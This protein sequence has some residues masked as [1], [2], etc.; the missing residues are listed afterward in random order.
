MSEEAEDRT[1]A[2]TPRRLQK[3]REEGQV[4]VSREMAGFASLAC[5]V[6]AASLALPAAGMSMLRSLQAL[7]SRSHAVLPAEALSGLGRDAL[8]AVLPVAAAAALG[9]VAATLLQTGGL[10]SAKG[11][12]PQLSR[13]SPLA[14]VKRVLGVEGAGQLLR[15]L[16]KLGLVG[17]ALWWNLDDPTRLRSVMQASPAQ[18][19]A[20]AGEEMRGLAT[21]AVL[22]FGLVALGDF[23]WERFRHLRR[24]RMSREDLKEEHKESEGDPHLKARQRQL[25]QQASRR[26]MMAAVPRATV[27]VTNPT[28]YAVALAY[29]KDSGAPRVVA[30]GM[31]SMAGRI[32][33][34]AREAG[35]PLVPNPPLARALYKLELGREIPPDHYA[36][37]AEIIAFV[38]RRRGG[39]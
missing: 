26:R 1:E 5:A 21:A 2:P 16:L 17:L 11:L 33:E 14:G 31:D 10:F 15:A 19:L 27:V 36:A 38:W 12:V 39:R 30:K 37:V 6:L 22:A 9:A 4:A 35:V 3:A 20:V 13:L 7:L 29:E 8:L 28:H 25:R 34:A 18:L 32:R 23:G 24:M